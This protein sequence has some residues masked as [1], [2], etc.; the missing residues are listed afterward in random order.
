VLSQKI[1]TQ[2]QKKFNESKEYMSGK[3]AERAKF[4]KEQDTL[5]KTNKIKVNMMHQMRKS[6][7]SLFKK[8]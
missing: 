3:K 1:I 5:N 8:E 7:V 4:D 2:I 6:F